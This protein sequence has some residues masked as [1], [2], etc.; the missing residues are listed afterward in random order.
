LREVRYVLK[1]TSIVHLRNSLYRHILFAEGGHVKVR[2]EMLAERNVAGA[3]GL[4]LSTGV[5]VV[6]NLQ[7]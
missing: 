5:V 6:N 3:A 1:G 2:Y 7:E 4:L